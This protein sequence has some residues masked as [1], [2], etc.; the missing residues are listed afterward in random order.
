MPR[1]SRS[2][3]HRSP[4]KWCDLYMGPLT[5]QILDLAAYRSTVEILR[6]AHSTAVAVCLDG[7]DYANDPM[8]DD[9]RPQ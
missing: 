7:P 9:Y 1:S 6:Q 2:S 8:Y 3:Q 5:F 4:A